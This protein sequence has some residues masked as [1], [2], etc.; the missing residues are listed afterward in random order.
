MTVKFTFAGE[1]LEKDVVPSNKK[2]PSSG[3]IYAPKGWIGGKARIIL[4][5]K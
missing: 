3:L 1:M 4:I 2:K 5:E